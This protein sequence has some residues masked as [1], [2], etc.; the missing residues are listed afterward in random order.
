MF[1]LSDRLV[2][3]LEKVL[4]ATNRTTKLL[5]ESCDEAQ[6]LLGNW[7]IPSS[8]VREELPHCTCVDY[9]DERSSE[10]T[11]VVRDIQQV[12][13]RGQKL[14]ET[15]GA[16]KPEEKDFLARKIP[17]T[18]KISQLGFTSKDHLNCNVQNKPQNTKISGFN[19][20]LITGNDSSKRSINTVSKRSSLD[21]RSPNRTQTNSDTR[22]IGNEVLNGDYGKKP[23]SKVRLRPSPT[24]QTTYQKDFSVRTNFNVGKHRS[25]KGCVSKNK[26]RSVKHV[27]AGTFPAKNPEASY[28]NDAERDRN[29]S[30][31]MSSSEKLSISNLEDLLSRVTVYPNAGVN[32]NVKIKLPEVKQNSCVF[33]GDKTAEI[34]ENSYRTVKLA[35][36]V[37][38]LGVPSDLVTVLKTYHNF[39]QERQRRNKPGS[40]AVK[41]QGAARSFLNK[42]STMV[43]YNK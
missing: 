5:H 36:A 35:E 20:P 13:E 21:N 6:N 40:D 22:S 29:N 14:R 28:G 32:T 37:D 27:D 18:R 42:L 31:R 43:S 1:S 17:K 11:E 34:A 15:S 7:H 25:A 23:P 10:I 30:D 38:V 39:F 26:E 2:A 24:L 41:G 19:K 9:D 8:S 12:V 4:H 3:V 33:H 16:S